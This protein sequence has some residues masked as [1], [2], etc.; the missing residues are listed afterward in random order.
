[1]AQSDV[2]QAVPLRLMASRITHRKNI[3]LALRVVAAMRAAGRP[4]G[5]TVTGPVDP[6]RPAGGAMR[7]RP[8]FLLAQ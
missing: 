1:M 7:N 8:G 2:F 4:A 3:E 5:L 6:H